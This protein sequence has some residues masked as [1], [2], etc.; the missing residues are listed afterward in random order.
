VEINFFFPP[1]WRH[2]MAQ[3]YGALLLGEIVKWVCDFLATSI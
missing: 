1:W 2:G 3:K